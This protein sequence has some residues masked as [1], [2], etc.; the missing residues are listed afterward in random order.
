MANGTLVVRRAKHLGRD[1]FRVYTLAVDHDT[2]LRLKNGAQEQLE[3]KAGPHL[4]QATIDWCRSA[5]TL[6]HIVEGETLTV[7]V[8][9][10][11]A[12]RGVPMPG[13]AFADDY[14]S[15]A[16]ESAR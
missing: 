9:P 2:T 6:I 3:L 5:I 10:N 15:V 1:M 7:V 4:I 14:I 12:Y 13:S 11:F 16:V 8:A